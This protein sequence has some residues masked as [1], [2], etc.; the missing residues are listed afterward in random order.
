M[1]DPDL[2]R[3]TGLLITRMTPAQLLEARA[4]A[5]ARGMYVAEYVRERLAPRYLVLRGGAA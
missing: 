5:A 1:H 4:A 2:V 3:T